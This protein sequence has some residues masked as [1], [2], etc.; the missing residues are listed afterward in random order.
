MA[1]KPSPVI[2]SGEDFLGVQ[3]IRVD[4]YGPVMA[5]V[6]IRF[7]SQAREVMPLGDLSTIFAPDAFPNLAPQLTLDPAG[8]CVEGQDSVRRIRRKS[9]V[10]HQSH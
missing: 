6:G 3:S 2:H 4:S 9:G 10:C 1:G 8:T 5:L 7:L